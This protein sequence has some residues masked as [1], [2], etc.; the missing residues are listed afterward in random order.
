MHL[1]LTD[2]LIMKNVKCLIKHYFYP[3]FDLKHC[4][5]KKAKVDCTCRRTEV[6]HNKN[7][8]PFPAPR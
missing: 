8:R 7:G 5:M 2:N 6:D 4:S 3:V 1:N